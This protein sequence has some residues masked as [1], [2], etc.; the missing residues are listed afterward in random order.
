MKN[1][2]AQALGSI[3]TEKK[4]TAAREN[5]AKGGRPLVWLKPEGAGNIYRN[6]SATH[7][8]TVIRNSD[9]FERFTDRRPRPEVIN[10][11]DFT[12]WD[13]RE[14]CEVR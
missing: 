3:R 4:S 10:S 12:V 11:L 1:K 9:K 6:D 8:Y 14:N 13:N 2:A 7:R 5:G